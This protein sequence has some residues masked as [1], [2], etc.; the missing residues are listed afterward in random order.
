MTQTATTYRT[1]ARLLHWVMALLVLMTIPAGVVMVQ[2]GISRQL[3]NSLFIF[4]KNVGVLLLVLVAL[5]LIYRWRVAPPPLPA[6]MPDWQKRAANLSHAGLYTLLVLVPV[7]GYTRVKAGG[8]PIESLDAMGVPSFVPRSDA[9]ASV[10][11]TVHF[12]GGLAIG[13]LIALHVAA[14]LQHG[15]LKR[16]GVF[17]RMWPP[18]RRS[19]G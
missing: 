6:A 1:P 14:A 5:R 7:A 8:F 16:D 9:L 13:A 2:E 19:G 12:L 3:Q 18:I 15:L 17:T 10:A 11:Q 4:H